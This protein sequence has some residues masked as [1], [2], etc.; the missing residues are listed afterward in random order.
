MNRRIPKIGVLVLAATALV[1]GAL[2]ARSGDST[3][4]ASVKAEHHLQAALNKAMWMHHLQSAMSGDVE[5]ATSDFA[6]N[7]V[8]FTKG[9]SYAGKDQIRG[10][11][12]GFV[13]AMTPEAAK[14][15]KVDYETYTDDTI[16]F[17]FTV[18]AWKRSGT[19]FVVVK[20]GKFIYATSVNYPSE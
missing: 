12:A 15:V 14:S 4:L 5:A 20:D 8:L 16:F 10:Y 13:K 1:G 6:D 9:H 19:N 17:N 2:A 7:A 18:G 3:D 11:V